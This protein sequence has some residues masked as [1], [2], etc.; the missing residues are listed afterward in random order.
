L[1]KAITRLLFK[2]VRCKVIVSKRTLFNLEIKSI[3]CIGLVCETCNF[4]SQALNSSGTYW[5]REWIQLSRERC[6][7]D[8][9]DE[10]YWVFTKR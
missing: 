2:T 8:T 6:R 9:G 4:V 1:Y 7:L 3:T 5:N 10:S